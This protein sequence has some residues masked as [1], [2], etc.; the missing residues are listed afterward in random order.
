MKPLPSRGLGCLP[1]ASLCLSS[2]GTQVLP[3]LAYNPEPRGRVLSLQFI[4]IGHIP[5]QQETAPF[6]LYGLWLDC[7]A[8]TLVLFPIRVNVTHAEQWFPEQLGTLQ[9]WCTLT[10]L[11]CKSCGGKW[12]KE[13]K[14]SVV[15][16]FQIGPDLVYPC[17]NVSFC[18]AV[19]SKSELCV[20]SA[21]C[22]LV[23]H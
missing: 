9:A 5:L 10:P 11:W 2:S 4:C 23:D 19:S 14:R 17:N 1:P 12:I 13:V 21:S 8:W 16:F 7:L 15:V 20:A 3:C 22:Y 18:F 6:I